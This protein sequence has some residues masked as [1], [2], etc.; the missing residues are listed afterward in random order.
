MMRKKDPNLLFAGGNAATR[1]ESRLEVALKQAMKWQTSQ[2]EEMK[3]RHN[4][5]TYYGPHK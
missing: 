4:G 2:V 1:S 3:T 5:H